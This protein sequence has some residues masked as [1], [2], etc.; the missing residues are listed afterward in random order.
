MEKERTATLVPT[1]MGHVTARASVLSAVKQDHG[2]KHPTGTE[3]RVE[4]QAVLSGTLL[5]L[6]QDQTK[7]SGGQRCF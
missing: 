6:F 5:L 1:L 7:T 2:R 4:T 3:C